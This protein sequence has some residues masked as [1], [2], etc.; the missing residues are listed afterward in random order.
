MPFTQEIISK[1]NES[2]T[3]D[4]SFRDFNIH[5][6]GLAEKVDKTGYQSETDY[7][8]IFDMKGDKVAVID[9][10][11]DGVIYHRITSPPDYE[12]VD[13][14]GDYNDEIEST[15]L[16]MVVWAI[17]SRL[18]M[19]KDQL[20]SIIA[21]KLPSTITID[22]DFIRGVIITKRSLT[23]NAKDLFRQEYTGIEYRINPE[24][25]FIGVNYTIET[26]YNKACLTLC[27]DCL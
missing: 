10:M 23:V 2:L 16:V 11:Y 24:D 27:E 18:R 13:G 6:L 7:P 1:I 22:R 21:A 15:N 9:D 20:A 3:S 19:T 14:F 25:L 4:L 8:V 26:T 17:P 5:L 12:E